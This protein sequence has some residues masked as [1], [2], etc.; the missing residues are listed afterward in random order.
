MVENLSSMFRALGSIFSNTHRYKLM[1]QP[2]RLG[3]IRKLSI[4]YLVHLQA[5]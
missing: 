5:E 4:P 2:V 3:Q 1:Y